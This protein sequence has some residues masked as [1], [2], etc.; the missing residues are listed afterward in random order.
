MYVKDLIKN[1]ILKEFKLIS[2][3]VISVVSKY[4]DLDYIINTCHLDTEEELYECIFVIDEILKDC[5]NCKVIV[6]ESMFVYRSLDLNAEIKLISE[7]K[8]PLVWDKEHKC[9]KVNE[10]K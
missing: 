5:V 1:D 8:E 9:W 2:H 3:P 4:L 10:C 6:G 7:N